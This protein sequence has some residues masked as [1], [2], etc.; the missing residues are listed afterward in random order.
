LICNESFEVF[1][2]IF[3]FIGKAILLIL[4]FIIIGDKSIN[5][6]NLREKKPFYY[7]FSFT[8]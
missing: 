5:I 6:G 3:I 8:K 1:I 7:F 2:F 4:L